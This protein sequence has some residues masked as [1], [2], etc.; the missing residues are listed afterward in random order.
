[1]MTE[2][3]KSERI[4]REIKR[5]RQEE[6][7]VD[8][9]V[10]TTKLVIYSLAGG[11]FAFHGHHVKEIIVPGEI[12]Y[13]PGSPDFLLGAI[14]IR[15]DIESVIALDRILTLPPAKPSPFNRILLAEYRDVRSG[16]LIEKIASYG[17]TTGYGDTIFNFCF[18]GSGICH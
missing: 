10:E 7:F 14:N 4:L 2:E 17:D 13:V 11:F 6:S 9:D 12:S 8:V 18:F 3:P 1:M 16:V 15:G 5:I